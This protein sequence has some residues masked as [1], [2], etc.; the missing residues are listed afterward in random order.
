MGVR[1]EGVKGATADIRL[2]SLPPCCLRRGD[3]LC[4]TAHFYAKTALCWDRQHNR[5]P[6]NAVF[7]AD[8]QVAAVL[9][10]Q[11]LDGACAE[12]VVFLVL[13]ARLR[14]PVHKADFARVVVLAVNQQ[15]ITRRADGQGDDAFLLLRHG[16]C[17]L[18]RV[19]KDVAEQGVNVAVLHEADAPPVRQ[20]CHRD[21]QI[22]ARQHLA[23]Q[24]HVQRGILRVRRRIVDVDQLTDFFQF[25]LIACI[26]QRGNLVADIVAFEV[27]GVVN[28][29]LLLIAPLLAVQHL[30]RDIRLA[31]VF[32]FPHSVSAYA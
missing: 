31:F 22:R 28:L 26:A 30:R 2:F 3:T 13:L 5:Q 29:P 7:G 18:N 27:D 21:A 23:T 4:K 14:Q 6:E 15:Q 10:R 9:L 17:R 8:F 1:C 32:R 25:F 12:A 19:V 20:T 16:L 11:R 24:R